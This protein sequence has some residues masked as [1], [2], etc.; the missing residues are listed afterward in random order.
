M[1]IIQAGRCIM[2]N[3][4]NNSIAGLILIFLVSIFLAL[5]GCSRDVK[6]SGGMLVDGVNTQATDRTH[7]E[8]RLPDKDVKKDKTEENGYK[9]KSAAGFKMYVG[10]YRLQVG[11]FTGTLLLADENGLYSGTIRFDGWGNNVPQP[12][13][14]LRVKDGKIYF[15]RSITTAEEMK[16]YGSTRYFVQ[17]YHGTFSEDGKAIRGRYVDSG[18]EYRWEASK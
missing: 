10:E 12:L 4:Q 9:D 7:A 1:Y 2:I 14:D 18:T 11:G 13:K 3:G 15:V 8:D 5:T 16:K 6:T 17:T